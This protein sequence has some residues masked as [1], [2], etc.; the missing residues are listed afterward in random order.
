M[1][2]VEQFIN[3]KLN[4]TINSYLELEE[5]ER[6]IKKSLLRTEFKLPK[7]AYKIY[8]NDT[9]IKEIKNESK[10]KRFN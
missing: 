3:D 5:I 9:L 8:K 2:R 7:V 1:Y 10:I 4:D 6:R